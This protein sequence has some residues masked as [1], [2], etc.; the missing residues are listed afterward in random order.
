M[1]QLRHSVHCLLMVMTDLIVVVS[2]EYS[3]TK[4]LLIK[5]VWGFPVC[6][7]PENIA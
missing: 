7:A 1:T 6:Q 4:C 5:I 2:T 3:L